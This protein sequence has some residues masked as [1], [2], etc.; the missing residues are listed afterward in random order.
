[1]A[2][3]AAG[4]ADNIAVLDTAAGEVDASLFAQRI[5]PVLGELLRRFRALDPH[6]PVTYYSRGTGPQQWRALDGLPIACLGVDWR[7][8]LAQV[9]REFGDRWCIQGNVDPDWLLLPGPEMETRVRAVFESVLA[10]PAALRAAWICG[11]G[12]GILQKTPEANVRRFVQL[13]RELFG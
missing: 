12:H 8:E 2:D 4:G 9:L 5:V 1:M 7:H 10:L 6:T 3:Q 11:L 13:Q